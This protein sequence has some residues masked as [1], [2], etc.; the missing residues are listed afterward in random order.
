MS[1]EVYIVP[2]IEVITLEL[3]GMVASSLLTPP[4]I[5]PPITPVDPVEVGEL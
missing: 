3:E 4:N 1:Q 5:L 2:S